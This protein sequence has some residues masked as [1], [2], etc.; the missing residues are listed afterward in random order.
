MNARAW[1]RSAR[2]ASQLYLGL[3]LAVGWSAAARAGHPA[4]PTSLL[5]LH[6]YGFAQQLFIVWANDVADEE[7]DR[8][9]RTATP[10]SGG[11]RVL[12]KD[13]LS[14][15][16][17]TR[18]Y[19]AAAAAALGITV[20]IAI[21]FDRPM[22]PLFGIAGIALL[23][24]YSFAPLR[25]S[26]R[27]GGAWLQVAG[28]GLHLPIFALYLC[29]APPSASTLLPVAL[30]LPAQFACAIATTLPD[31]PSDRSSNKRSFTVVHGATT[32]TAVAT[33]GLVASAA[34]LFATH[35]LRP[36]L[37]AALACALAQPL[38]GQAPPGTR[39]LT[40][41]LALLVGAALLLQGAVVM[42]P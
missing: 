17:L 38:L 10:F 8:S 6:A 1:L 3:A 27:G 14:S 25:L 33:L 31:E 37:V 16:A 34:S 20:A 15:A 19:R 13:E 23:Q 35:A 29:G 12:A 36:L 7:T 11:S 41:R 22:A 18:A 28:L 39:V 4:P 32:T 9:N 2:P 40:V 5:L 26:Y 24:A 30:L 21:A 42:A